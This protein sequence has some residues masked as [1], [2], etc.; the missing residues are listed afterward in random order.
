MRAIVSAE[1]RKS[2]AGALAKTY[3]LSI[4]AIVWAES[5]LAAIWFVIV[6]LKL[7]SSP[8]AAANSFNVL[9]APGAASTIPATSAST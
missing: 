2:C 1:S 4:I 9:S 3:A 8:S 7:A 5:N 6:V